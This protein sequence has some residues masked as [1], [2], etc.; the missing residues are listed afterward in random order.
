MLASKVSC[1]LWMF[2][3]LSLLSWLSMFWHTSF[4]CSCEHSPSST[5]WGQPVPLLRLFLSRLFVRGTRHFHG[6]F[7]PHDLLLSRAFCDFFLSV[8]LPELFS[9]FSVPS[10]VIVSYPPGSTGLPLVCLFSGSLFV[11]HVTSFFFLSGSSPGS[12][13]VLLLRVFCGLFSCLRLLEL[14]SHPFRCASRV[15]MWEPVAH[16]HNVRLMTPRFG[17]KD[18]KWCLPCLQ[19]DWSCVFNDLGRMAAHLIR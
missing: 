1:L 5:P 14:F 17:E 18:R 13:N 4:S 8:R 19:I 7:T 11:T 2:L 15:A 10:A 12:H 9:R 3:T 6:L 16:Y